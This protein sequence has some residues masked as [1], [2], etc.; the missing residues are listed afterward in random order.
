MKL[1]LSSD[2]PQVPPKGYFL[3]KIF[4]PNISKSGE[5][6]VNTLKKVRPPSLRFSPLYLSL[7]IHYEL[8]TVVHSHPFL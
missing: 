2:F 1:V 3:T 8:E 5:I 6:C 7:D 4:H